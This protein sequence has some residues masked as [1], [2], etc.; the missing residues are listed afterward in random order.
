MACNAE[1]FVTASKSMSLRG[2]VVSPPLGRKA[3]TPRSVLLDSKPLTRRRG[4]AWLPACRHAPQP[5]RLRSVRR[6]RPGFPAGHAQLAPAELRMRL[7]GD[8]E[9]VWIEWPGTLSVQSAPAELLPRK[10]T[11]WKFR[12]TPSDIDKSSVP[13]PFQVPRQVDFETC[14][15]Q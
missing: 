1:C 2:D 8:S 15:L 7:Q 6:P 10:G 11:F 5:I 12:W 9:A 14:R 4:P 13:G 3:P